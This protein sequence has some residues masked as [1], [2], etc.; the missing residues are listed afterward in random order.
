[1]SLLIDL[2]KGLSYL[3]NNTSLGKHGFLT[4]KNCVVDSKWLL[5]ITDFG[6]YEFHRLQNIKPDVLPLQEYLWTAPELLNLG[7]SDCLI[8]GTKESDFY[9]FG[10]IMQELIKRN[11][12][13]RIEDL[14]FKI[15]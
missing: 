12:Y 10:L 1:M 13:L 2:I 3:H 4:S 15:N 7:F 11:I 5:K 9:S 8:S 14:L 6:F